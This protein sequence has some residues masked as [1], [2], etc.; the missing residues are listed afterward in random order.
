M[1]FCRVVAAAGLALIELDQDVTHAL[2]DLRSAPLSA[3][4]P[5][6][7]MRVRRLVDRSLA[8]EQGVGIDAGLLLLGVGDGARDQLLDEGSAALER[9]V[10]KLQ[11]FGG[12][13]AAHQVDDHPGLTR[14]NP[15]KSCSCRSDHATVSS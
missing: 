9:E 5:A 7:K 2:G 1:F 11:G 12:V 6:P 14:T 10:Q 15:L 4:A 3:R 8:D 13:T